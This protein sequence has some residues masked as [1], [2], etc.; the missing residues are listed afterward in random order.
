M[1]KVHEQ[2]NLSA[3]QH[4]KKPDPRFSCP[5]P[6][7]K[8]TGHIAAAPGQRPQASGALSFS[9]INKL[10]KSSQFKSCR[11]QGL[12]FYSRSFALTVMNRPADGLGPRL[13]LAVSR[14]VGTA[15]CRNRVK[16][17]LREFFRLI[18]NNCPIDA[19]IVIAAK[20][21]LNPAE[22]GLQNVWAELGPQFKKIGLISEDI[23][24][25]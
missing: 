24:L 4:Q 18:R 23:F 6:D 7:K 16:R 14:K 22:I 13:G 5:L 9:P 17:V 10:R 21:V 20:P 2:E 25:L 15:V 19:D 8:R 3:K 1:E 11:E 12:R